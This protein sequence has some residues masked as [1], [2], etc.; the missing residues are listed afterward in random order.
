M[1][2][3]T[4]AALLPSLSLYFVENKEA[5]KVLGCTENL[6][7]SELCHMVGKDEG[8]FTSSNYF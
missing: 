7:S 4:V 2:I 1:K 5:L 6:P 8:S 3:L